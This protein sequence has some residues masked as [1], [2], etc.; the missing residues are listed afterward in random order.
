MIGMDFVG[1]LILLIISVIV[2][3]IIHF[4]FKYYIIPG[5]GSFYLKL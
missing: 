3:A 4:G 2:T 5:W 1:F